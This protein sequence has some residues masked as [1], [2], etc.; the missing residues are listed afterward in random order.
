MA[1]ISSYELETII[2]PNDKVIGTDGTEGVDQGKTKNFTISKLTEYLST[3]LD[4]TPNTGLEAINESGRN[5]FGST[6]DPVGY[7]IVNRDPANF[8]PIGEDAIDLSTGYVQDQTLPFGGSITNS[9]QMGSVGPGSITLGG[10]NENNSAG[11]VIFGSANVLNGGPNIEPT[12]FVGNAIFGGDNQSYGLNYYNLIG[13][14]KNLIGDRTQQSWSDA[15]FP[16][17]YAV[18]YWSGQIGMYNQMPAGYASAQIGYGLLSSA[19]GSI[20]VGVANSDETLQ[21]AENI[22][23]NRNALNPRFVVGCG[24][25]AGN[26][27]SPSVG[28]RQNGFVVMSDG[29]A[30]FPILTNVMIDAA[31]D[32]SA[33]TKGYVNN[34]IETASVVV[35]EELDAA[36]AS[37]V[38]TMRYRTD[39][40]NSYAEMV[41]QT[42]ASTYDWVTIKQNTW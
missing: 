33:V 10:T 31:G 4:F 6:D 30:K 23:N 14:Y 13:G 26:T 37:N 21:I 2:D 41:M 24:T 19:P 42:G 8:G 34:Q 11:G 15:G 36:S 9:Q 28:V 29:T 35:G 27:A 3:A 5:S 25:F 22:V 7:R 38:G 40:N 16:Y 17:P 18:Q 12:Y 32:D 20:T 39:A 1:N